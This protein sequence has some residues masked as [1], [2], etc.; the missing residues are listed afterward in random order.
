[1]GQTKDERYAL[2]IEKVRNSYPSIHQN[3]LSEL[4]LYWCDDCQ[5]INLW[6]YW[7]GRGHLNASVMLVGQDWG[8]PWDPSSGNTMEQVCMAN[9]GMDYDYLLNNPSITD[10]NL[11]EL[12]CHIG[13]PDIRHPHG[14]LFFTNYILG[15]R[16]H[17][18][19]GGYRKKW[20]EHAGEHFRELANIVEPNVILCLGKTTFEGVVGSLN[21]AERICVGRYNAFIESDKNPVSVVLDG[22]KMV[23]VFALAH[24]GALGTMNRNRGHVKSEDPLE[25]QKR[26]WEKIIPYLK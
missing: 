26:D 20:A 17:G 21:V 10:C 7:Q 12:F 4:G 15:Y 23:H 8:S 5:E 14:E 1:M 19:S 16:N 9:Q 13:F 25:A 2:L 6:T 22:G 18:T 24:C 11:S 3:Q